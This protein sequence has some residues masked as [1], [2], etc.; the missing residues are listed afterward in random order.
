MKKIFTIILLAAVLCVP[1]RAQGVKISSYP[2]TTTLPPSYLFL[3]AAPGTTNY[4]F[5]STNLFAQINTWF[6]GASLW[7]NNAG[8]IQPNNSNVSIPYLLVTNFFG[9]S[10]DG[11]AN[12]FSVQPSGYGDFFGNNTNVIT[13][14]AAQDWFPD[15]MFGMSWDSGANFPVA[16]RPAIGATSTPFTFDTDKTHTSGFLVT[17]ANNGTNR[18]TVDYLGNII[19]P[20]V[21]IGSA[22]VATFEGITNRIIL[23]LS[24]MTTAL[25]T[26]TNRNYWI[27]KDACTVKYVR[28]NVATVSS[29]GLPTFDILEGATSILSTL[30]TIDANERSSDTAATPPVISDSA[31]AAGA[32]VNISQTVAGTAAAGAQLEIGYTVP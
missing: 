30:I 6:P 31:I 1:N 32:Y 25:T 4:K 2:A 17:V 22:P 3:I 10:S 15:I 11:F 24:D 21:T 16:L 13:F 19:A 29:S 5:S 26:G 23:A 20:S 28:A 14:A 12:G 8:T 27:P 18:L 7:T 9:V